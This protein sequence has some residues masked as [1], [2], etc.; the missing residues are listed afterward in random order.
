MDQLILDR[1]VRIIES[2]F[3]GNLPKQLERK[4]MLWLFKEENSAEKETALWTV[5]NRMTDGAPEQNE[6]EVS[7]RFNELCVLFELP[8]DV[9]VMKTQAEIEQEQAGHT[10]PE[11]TGEERTGRDRP[12]KAAIRLLPRRT[13]QKVAAVL[14]P[15]LVVAG[16]AIRLVQRTG[17][18]GGP[19]IAE[20][21]TVSVPAGDEQ[22]KPLDNAIIVAENS[23]VKLPDSSTVRLA[24]GSELRRTENF[25][26]SREVELKGE[27]T[28]N[29]AQAKDPADVFT[30]HTEQLRIKVLGTEFKVH[31]FPDEDYS[32]VDLYHGSVRVLSDDGSITM[33]PGEHLHYEHATG[34]MRIS[35][36][37]VTELRYDRMPGLAF[38]NGTLGDIFATLQA[39][40]GV[41]FRIE[42]SLSDNDSLRLDFTD[43]NTL[44][45]VMRGLK[46]LSGSFDYE[47]TEDEI[48]VKPTK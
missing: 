30:V 35:K 25:G 34:E 27:A 17:D 12:R 45:D 21:V 16:V 9:P 1:S 46:R 19:P 36:I 15:L 22:G 7:A 2:L 5:F 41:R 39:Q 4:I 40:Y 20:V 18:S 6:Q 3:T 42:N 29:V 14:V 10:K 28:F 48:I 23:V 43:F 8:A 44:H 33:H 13:I 47:I 38:Q 24:K 32:T 26:G 37:P 31:S 11:Q